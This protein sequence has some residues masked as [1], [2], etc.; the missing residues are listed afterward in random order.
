MAINSKKTIAALV[1]SAALASSLMIAGCGSQQASSASA[2]SAASEE[3]T[4]PAPDDII[5]KESSEVSA[6]EIKNS[7]GRAI[8]GVQAKGAAAEGDFLALEIADGEWADG[9][10]AAVYF[11]P[12]DS[13]VFT[14]QIVCDGQ[15]FTLHNVDVSDLADAEVVIE[16]DIAYITANRGEEAINT[17]EEEKSIHEAEVAAAEAAAAEAAAA[18]AAAAEEETYYYEPAPSYSAPAPSQ[19]QDSCVGGGVVLR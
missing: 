9:A 12:V 18:E 8:G 19:S 17:L 6:L 2:S 10:L 16:G 4:K 5:G 7:T 15:T 3:V 11:E 1:L 14:I 13:S